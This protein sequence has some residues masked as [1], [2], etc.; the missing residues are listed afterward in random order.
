M[1]AS[2]DWL[3]WPTSI[4]WLVPYDLDELIT[5]ARGTLEE[6]EFARIYA[7]GQALTLEKAVPYALDEFR[8]LGIT[9]G[10]EFI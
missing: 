10:F 2:R 6:A 7:E 3:L 4:P 1:I 8:S 5:K 9:N